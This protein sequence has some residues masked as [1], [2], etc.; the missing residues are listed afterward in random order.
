MQTITPL[1]NFQ[2]LIS[3]RQADWMPFTLDVGAISGFTEPALAKFRQATGSDQPA[4]FFDYDFRIASLKACF[5]GESPAALH[6]AVEPGTTFDEW[7]IGHWAGGAAGTY[8]KIYP[9]LA[10]AESIREV[11]ALPVP[12]LDPDRPVGAV[13]AYHALGYPV[14]GYAGSAY[15][16][17]WWLRG[18]QAFMTD[19]AANAGMA[20]AI[21]RKVADYTA[22]LALETARTGVDILCFYDDAGM[23]SG[24]QISPK[25]WRRFVKPRWREILDLLRSAYPSCIFFLHSC[26][27]IE[28]IIPDIIEVGFHILHP[29]QPECMDFQ[30]IHATYGRDLILCACI[31]AQQLF[32]FGTPAD[33]TDWVDRTKDR[34]ALDNRIILCPS[35]RI[36]PETPWENIVAFAAAARSRAGG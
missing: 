35:N 20:E 9:P 19:L 8:E 17:S 4:E 18:M 13:D 7:G 10:R 22:G 24:M 36:Q 3:A 1:T 21:I 12:R 5:A 14:C 15:E 16:W 25:M 29:V 27:K 2:K 30:K 32:P 26:G 28:A 23:Q 11:E 34:Y 31:S 6:G 33:V